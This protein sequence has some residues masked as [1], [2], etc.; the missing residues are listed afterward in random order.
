MPCFESMREKVYKRDQ[1]KCTKCNTTN[2]FTNRRTH[3]H[4]ITRIADGGSNDLENLVTLCNK[5]HAEIHSNKFIHSYENGE[6]KSIEL[7]IKT[8]HINTEFPTDLYEKLCELKES[9]RKQGIRTS[10]NHL[11]VKAIREYLAHP[12][13]TDI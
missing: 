1:N 9:N 11:I 7:N 5:F 3:V 2:D 13:K 6:W 4:H 12:E 10:I 8:S